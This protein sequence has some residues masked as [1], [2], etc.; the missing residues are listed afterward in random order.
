MGALI[1]AVIIVLPFAVAGGIG[2]YRHMIRLRDL[3]GKLEAVQGETGELTLGLHTLVETVRRDVELVRG[4][5]AAEEQPE[6]LGACEEHLGAAEELL[7]RY[8]DL[9]GG[10]SA[11]NQAGEVAR[12]MLPGLQSQEGYPTAAL[13]A[14]ARQW[15]QVGEAMREIV[16]VLQTEE[17][18]LTEA[19]TR[20]RE[21]P[22]RLEQARALAGQARAAA[23][24]GAE[25]G[26]VVDTEAEVLDT[27]AEHI[28]EVAHLAE[29]RR[30]RAA[31]TALTEL[32]AELTASRDALRS[33]RRRRAD[34]T[35][36]LDD[37]EESLSALPG[38]DSDAAAQLGI[39]T[40]R[41]AA[42][43]WGGL[44]ARIEQGRQHSARAAVEL[45]AARRHLL[46]SDPGRGELAAE[47]AEAERDAAQQKF[48]VPAERLER[49]RDL[50]VALPGRKGELLQRAAAL[51]QSV[52]DNKATRP[53]HPVVTELRAQLD[54]LDMTQAKPPWLTYEQRLAE[55]DALVGETETAAEQVGG[56]AE[57][58]L[59]E[60]EAANTQLRRAHARIADLEAGYRDKRRELGI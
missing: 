60:L 50:R 51:A 56:A 39:L 49:V 37:V 30:L 28:A 32:A 11:R 46:A 23:E 36:R 55:L 10:A 38:Q 57:R 33:L 29:E 5:F 54:A 15:R 42:E 13:S 22:G 43:A 7:R 14:A 6:V 16:P 21:L 52:Q 34:L 40:E 25:D 58:M 44:E 2:L 17:E 9:S 45:D 31:D 18:R 59:A 8:S 1:L 41:F 35:S 26:F 12:E 24:R 53:L 27:A 20:A 48:A 3:R 47:E 19:L 4:A